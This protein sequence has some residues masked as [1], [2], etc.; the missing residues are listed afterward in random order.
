[1]S[2]KTLRSFQETAVESGVALFTTAKALLECA[3][4][5]AASR[6]AAINHNGYLLIEAPTGAGK[7]LMAGTIVERFSHEEDVVWFWFAPFRGVTGQTAA[8]LREQFHGLRL[9]EL[10]DDRAAAMSRRGDVFVTTWQTVAT[11]VKDKRNV[12][13]EGDTNP[14]IDTLLETLR[15]AGLR[16][17]VVV[18]EA[19]HGF[20]GKTLAAE[21]FR[22]VLRPEYTILITATPDDADVRAFEKA[23]GIAELQRIR[24]SRADAVGAGLIKAGVKCAAYFV[25]AD[26]RALVDLQG[27]ALRDGVAAHRKLK[28]T[29][30]EMKIPLVPL[31]LVQADKSTDEIKARLLRMGFTEEQIAVHTAEE[32]DADLLALA[33]DERREVLVFKMAVALGFDAPRAF[34]MV[35]MRAARDADF[36][37]QLVGRIL[38]VHAARRPARCPRR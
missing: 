16:I 35:S 34:T 33:N 10:A 29:L 5:D 27:T 22:E 24:V 23:M 28:A 3:G 30:A 12:R 7:T 25:D 38:R 36:G 26:K 1:M 32:P 13:K 21:F 20:G 15:D 31:L 14:S 17:G 19:H 2:T 6:A 18:D 9:R 8:F 37:V 11:R 4:A